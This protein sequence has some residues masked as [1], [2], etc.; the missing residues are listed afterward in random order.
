MTEMDLGHPPSSDEL[1][2]L[3]TAAEQHRQRHP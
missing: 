2:D 1:A 3:V